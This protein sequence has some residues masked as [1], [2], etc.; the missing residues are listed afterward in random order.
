MYIHTA[1]LWR[2]FFEELY[3]KS[4]FLQRFL[5]FPIETQGL[6]VDCVL[7]II[8]VIDAYGEQDGVVSLCPQHGR[9]GGTTI[10]GWRWGLIRV[11]LRGWLCQDVY[12]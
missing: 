10:S 8:E 4:V 12:T 5:P 6:L 11:V 9:V 1:N 7:L 2:N 3:L